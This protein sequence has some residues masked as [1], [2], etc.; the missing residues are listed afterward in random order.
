VQEPGLYHTAR[1]MNRVHLSNS[2]VRSLSFACK[3]GFILNE[4]SPKYL[5]QMSRSHQ[6]IELTVLIFRLCIALATASA[7]MIGFQKKINTRGQ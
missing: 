6:G 7:Y 1:G 2:A 4:R 5:A 3:C